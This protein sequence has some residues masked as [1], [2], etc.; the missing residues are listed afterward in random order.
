MPYYRRVGSVPAKRHTDHRSA[1]GQRYTEELIG[2]HGFSGDSSLLYHRDSPSAVHDVRAD[3][4]EAVASRV[5]LP[6]RPHHLRPAELGTTPANP[7]QGRQPLLRNADVTISWVAADESSPLTRSVVGDEIVY[8]QSG[9]AVL[10]SVF[11]EVEVGAGDYVVV[12]AGVTHRWENVDQLRGLIVETTGVVAPPDRYLS[13]SGQ[14]LEHSP[15]CE[16][17]LRAPT[18][19]LLREGENVEVLIRSI[20]GGSWHT[21][22]HHP[23]GVEGWDGCVY[24]W[25]LNI[26][27]FEPVVGSIHQPPPVHQTFA[28]PGVVICSFVPRLFDFHPDAIKVP[29]HH[30][31]VDSDEVLFYSDG[32]FMSRR[33]SGIGVE[34]ISFHPAGFIH[35]PQPGS[36]EAS[37]DRDRTEETAVMIDTFRPLE[38]TDDARSISDPGYLSSWG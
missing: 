17:D 31:N 34:S 8:V 28:A 35:G 23:F 21:H 19:P 13:S 32:D 1:T 11:G 10:E 9:A 3:D 16:R 18:S 20:A 6:L 25:V 37:L 27:D 12:P 33:G 36:V 29:Y 7:V 30:A 24:P 4:A 38:M 2:R 22:A 15:Y 5:E 26:A 14:F